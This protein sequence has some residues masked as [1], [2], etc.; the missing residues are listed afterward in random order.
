MAGKSKEDRV[1]LKPPP[2]TW[3]SWGILLAYI[4]VFVEGLVLNV[5]HRTNGAIDMAGLGLAIFNLCSIYVIESVM[6]VGPGWCAMSPG[7]TCTELL[8]HH[9]P[10]V[11]AQALC[12]FGGHAVRWSGP[13]YLVILTALNEALFIV[14]SL[15]GP[16]WLPRL[17]R[18]F[19]FCIVFA[20]M[21][22]ECRAMAMAM[23]VHW[24]RGREAVGNAAADAVVSAA[25]YYHAN[26][27]RFYI[28]RWRKTRAL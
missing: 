1:E 24:L 15:G 25:I 18:L 10:F 6:A 7:W 2:C 8:Q 12:F 17:R 3:I 19:G 20:L 16:D 28:K 26:L 9:V 27:V 5:L 22:S 14:T 11:L 13:M 23:A 4:A 21:C